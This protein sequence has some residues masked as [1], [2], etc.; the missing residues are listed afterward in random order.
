MSSRIHVKEL[1]SLLDFKSY[2]AFEVWYTGRIDT[3]WGAEYVAYET[4]NTWFAGP[5]RC[6][7]FA[8]PLTIEQLVSREVVL[9]VPTRVQKLLLPPEESSLQ[10]YSRYYQDLLRQGYLAGVQL[11]NKVWRLS[12]ASVGS[13]IAE[14]ERAERETLSIPQV[15]HILGR[16]T[17][18]TLIERGSLEADPFKQGR[19]HAVL[20]TRRSLIE[21]IASSCDLFGGSQITPEEW[22]EARLASPFVLMGTRAAALALDVSDEK[23]GRTIDAGQLEGIRAKGGAYFIT[24]ESVKRHMV[25]VALGLV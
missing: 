3:V 7:G 11:K 1:A 9:V 25:N 2:N 16:Y 24:T 12:Y 4:L 5:E 15:R 17:V 6:Y 8:A 21:Y 13:F 19:N 20:V 22:I 14:R 23:V 10:R 18:H